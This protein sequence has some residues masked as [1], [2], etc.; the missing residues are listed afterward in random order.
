MWV[1]AKYKSFE[2]EILKKNMSKIVGREIKF[3]SPKIR[4]KKLNNKNK[5]I[6]IKKNILEDYI[7]FFDNSFK[8]E[9]FIKSLNN[10]K[11][12]KYFLDNYKQTQK[13]IK[14]FIDNC[15]KNEIDGYLNQNFFNQ[16]LKNRAIFVSGPL[17]GMIF[18]I[19]K[20]QGKKIKALMGNFETTINDHKDYLYKPL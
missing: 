6:E 16:A 4:I 20:I 15:L 10:T 9:K 14:N 1:I 8:D 19:I 3:Y 2:L 13:E 5:S 12:L 11:G 7:F 18:D 17:S